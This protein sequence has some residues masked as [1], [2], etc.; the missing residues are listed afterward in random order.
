MTVLTRSGWVKFTLDK[1]QDSVDILCECFAVDNARHFANREEAL[2]TVVVVGLA[3]VVDD[4]GDGVVEQDS[5]LRK[6]A[7]DVLIHDWDQLDALLLDEGATSCLVQLGHHLHD[8]TSFF[9]ATKKTKVASLRV[10]QKQS[11]QQL[12]K[13]KC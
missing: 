2:P 11:K 7:L 4:A 9:L 6:H 13:K 12:T 8:S 10:N 5:V 1:P 3:D